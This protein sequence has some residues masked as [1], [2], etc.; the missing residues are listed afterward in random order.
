MREGEYRK[1]VKD[2]LESLGLPQEFGLYY[3]GNMKAIKDS[4]QE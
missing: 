4:E 3:L 1:V 2:T